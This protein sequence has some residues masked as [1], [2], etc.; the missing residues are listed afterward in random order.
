M[1]EEEAVWSEAGDSELVVT[2]G[3]VGGPPLPPDSSDGVLLRNRPVPNST[4][5]IGEL[6]TTIPVSFYKQLC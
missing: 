2:A 5:F 1:D 6:C 4:R 3:V